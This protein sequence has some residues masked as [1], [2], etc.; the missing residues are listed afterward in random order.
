M[1]EL[2]AKNNFFNL[3]LFYL[4]YQTSYFLVGLD[5]HISRILPLPKHD[6][7]L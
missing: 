1:V 6:K 5:Q 4:L 3:S 7:Y 2:N